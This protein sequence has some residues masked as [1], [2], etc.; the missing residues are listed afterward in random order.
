MRSRYGIGVVGKHTAW[1][2][3]C[4]VVSPGFLSVE[5]MSIF[6]FFPSQGVR[7]LPGCNLIASFLYAFLMSSSE[8][9]GCTPS[10]S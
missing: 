1:N 5:K 4:A 6:N 3:S 2:F 8:A 10:A 9:V 7:I